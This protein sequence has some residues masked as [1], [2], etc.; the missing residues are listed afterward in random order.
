MPSLRSLTSRFGRRIS[1]SSSL[2]GPDRSPASVWAWTTHLRSGSGPRRASER[3]PDTRPTGTDTR[4][5][6]PGPSAPR[7][8][9]PRSGTASACCILPRNTAARKP[10]RFV[11]RPGKQPSTPTH[12]PP[13]APA[14]FNVGAQAVGEGLAGVGVGAVP[15]RPTG[16]T[17][18]SGRL[19][20]TAGGDFSVAAPAQ[21]RPSE[22]LIR[23]RCRRTQ[24]W[25][26][27]GGRGS[28]LRAD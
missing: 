24:P 20:A 19:D 13:D 1:S 18:R 27:G 21:S 7:A 17:H 12:E 8:P 22:V 26:G 10:G 3:C 9:E 2:V 25:S 28:S 23:V 6:G 15:G 11:T 16:N 4:R 14:R 5:A